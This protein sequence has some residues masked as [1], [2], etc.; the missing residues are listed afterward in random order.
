MKP[1]LSILLFSVLSLAARDHYT[2]EDIPPPPTKHATDQ[3]DA[4]CFTKDG[5]LAVGLPSGELWIHDL[6]SKNWSLFAEGLHNPLGLMAEGDNGL[7]V[8][9]RPELTLVKDSD[10]DGKADQYLCLTD[11][12]G[13]SGNYHEFNFTP[14]R[15]KDGHIFFALGAGS[16]GAGITQIVRGRF[17]PAGRPGRMHASVPYRGWVMRYSPEDGSVTPWSSGHRT[18][19]GLGMDLKGNL[20]ATDNQGD[21]VGTSKMFHVEKGNF[22]GHAASIN[23]R[24]DITEPALEMGAGKLNALRTRACVIFPHGIMAN[25]PTQPLVDDTGGKFGPFEGQ[26]FVGEMNSP[27]LMRVMLEEVD[28][29]LQGAC[30]PFWDDAGL[31]RGINRLAFAPDGSLYLGATRHTWAGGSGIQRISW[32]EEVPVDVL[33]VNL[34]KTGFKLTFTSEMDHELLGDPANYS[35]SRYWYDYHEA[36]GSPPHEESSVGIK[37][38]T[39]GGDGKSVEL[40]LDELKPWFVHELN[41][42]GLTSK[43][44][45]KLANTLICYTVNRLLENTPE[46]PKQWDT[47]N[48]QTRKRK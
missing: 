29:Y 35:C 24:E 32:N 47:P 21:W 7:I 31:S 42:Q 12:F 39:V 36:Y 37:K 34:T 19:N 25:S 48:P 13:L 6:K 43:D 20:F 4:L 28:G 3:I 27:R 41:L 40:E 11:D 33:D 38:V 16:K 14:V 30:I 8:T 1:S 26:L 46:P 44:G 2:I 45:T 5:R 22:Y 9:Q 18:P 10:G 23:W 17:D 15:A